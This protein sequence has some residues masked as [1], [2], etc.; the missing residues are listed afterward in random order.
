[1]T[2]PRQTTE[3]LEDQTSFVSEVLYSALRLLGSSMITWEPESLWA[4]FER[5]HHTQLSDL[6]KSKLLAG[7]ALYTTKMFCW[8]VNTFENAVLLCNNTQDNPDVLQEAYPHQIAWGVIEAREIMKAGNQHF[9]L[10]REPISYTAVV[11]HRDGFL[12]A[13]KD[14]E[15]AAEALRSLNRGNQDAVWKVREA[16]GRGE[17][18]SKD[19][20]IGLQLARLLSVGRYVRERRDLYKRRLPVEF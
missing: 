13:P 15:F 4:T 20:L 5:E 12:L 18:D 2:N 17:A 19:E 1:M 8:E 16:L 9:E 14:L 10:D 11:L 7:L 6:N 3:I